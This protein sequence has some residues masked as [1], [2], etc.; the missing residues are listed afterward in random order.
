MPNEEVLNLL[1]WR[2]FEAAPLELLNQRS[3]IFRQTGV[4][5]RG[6][7]CTVAGARHLEALGHN[8]ARN[9]NVS[10]EYAPG[11]AVS[12][13][14]TTPGGNGTTYWYPYIERGVGECHVNYDVAVGTTALTAGMNGCSLRLYVN[15]D[16]GILKFCHDNNGMYADD[17]AYAAKG[18]QH[19]QSINAGTRIRGNVTQN[20]NNYWLPAMDQPASGIYFLCRKTKHL[21][22]KIY[23]SVVIGG[24]REQRTP[25]LLSRSTQVVHRFTG[26]QSYNKVVA[27]V[28]IPA[29]AGGRR[30]RAS[31]TGD[32]PF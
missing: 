28:D 12:A 29:L 19:L 20:I 1:H 27:V 11:T 24:R 25:G 31:T 30:L 14:T 4:S 2:T 7:P 9:M 15:P 8:G 23:Q 3:L 32:L 6:G 21:Q 10:L 26:G 17:A 5:N 13:L 22:W 16:L 18:F